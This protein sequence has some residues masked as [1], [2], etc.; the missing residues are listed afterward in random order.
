MEDLIVDRDQWIMVN[1]STTPTGTSTD[2]WKKLVRK[3]K[4][5]I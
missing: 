4:S 2:N 1:L 5:T 3:E